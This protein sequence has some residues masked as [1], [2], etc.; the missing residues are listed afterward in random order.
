[1]SAKSEFNQAIND[2]LNGFLRASESACKINHLLF[3]IMFYECLR[4]CEW[5]RII[6]HFFVIPK[7]QFFVYLTLITFIENVNYRKRI[8]LCSFKTIFFINMCAGVSCRQQK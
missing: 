3:K 8:F 4:E 7:H 2:L 1:M 5:V 6:N